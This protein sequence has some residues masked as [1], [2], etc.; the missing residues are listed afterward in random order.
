MACINKHEPINTRVKY[1]T[2]HKIKDECYVPEQAY[3]VPDN[4]GTS[5]YLSYELNKTLEIIFRNYSINGYMGVNEF[6]RM[7]NVLIKHLTSIKVSQKTPHVER[8]NAGVQVDIKRE[9][10]EINAVCEMIDA[11]CDAFVDVKSIGIA[12]DEIKYENNKRTELHDENKESHNNALLNEKK[13]DNKQN[14]NNNN[15]SSERK[16]QNSEKLKIKKRIE[17]IE[18]AYTHK[19]ELNKKLKEELNSSLK[20]IEEKNVEIE[21]INKNNL[22]ELEKKDEKIEDLK[23]IIEQLKSEKKNLELKESKTNIQSSE[24]NSSKQL[25]SRDKLQDIEMDYL[26]LKRVVVLPCEEEAQLLKI[27]AMYSTYCGG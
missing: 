24:N 23:K 16:L 13:N 14:N 11:S 15:S 5:I 18:K 26:N 7:F 25:P 6:I 3:L 2:I 12:T 17:S 27:F 10:K 8:Y 19:D 4:E 22:K 9:C 21:N 1:K 20:I